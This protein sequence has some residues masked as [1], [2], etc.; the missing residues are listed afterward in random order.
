MARQQARLQSLQQGAQA[1]DRLLA[2][3][4][5][6]LPGESAGAV[7][8][9]AEKDGVVTVM[10]SRP[11]DATRLHYALPALKAALEHELDT[12]LVRVVLRVR[13]APAPGR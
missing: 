11:A 4:R 10:V 9:A 13:P 3:V 7:W 5:A 2:S 6:Q 12:P 8:A 1:A